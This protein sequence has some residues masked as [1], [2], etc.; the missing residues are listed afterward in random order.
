M[1]P[2]PAK[3]PY[4][5]ITPAGGGGT[6]YKPTAPAGGA[7]AKYVPITGAGAPSSVTNVAKTPAPSTSPGPKLTQ[8]DYEA[9][10]TSGAGPKAPSLLSQLW[11]HV[12]STAMMPM[13]FPHDVSMAIEHAG[14]FG[15]YDYPNPTAKQNVGTTQE[16]KQKYF[17][18]VTSQ[19]R[20]MGSTGQHLMNLAPIPRSVGELTG[21]N[22]GMHLPTG[23]KQNAQYYDEANKRGQIVSVLGQDLG[24]IAMFSG[25]GESLLGEA[26]HW[27]APLNASER[28]GVLG[29]DGAE[30]AGALQRANA[31]VD[32]LVGE[33]LQP[34]WVPGRGISGALQGPSPTASTFLPENAGLAQRR[35][36]PGTR[37]AWSA[38]TNQAVNPLHSIG[39]L[40]QEG[41]TKIGGPDVSAYRPS[42]FVP[43][44]AGAGL[45]WAAQ[46]SDT[47]NAVASH[48]SPEA[49]ANA[50]KLNDINAQ[51]EAQDLGA[52]RHALDPAKL[53]RHF[54]LSDDQSSAALNTID[55]RFFTLTDLIKRN[56]E[57]QKWVNGDPTTFDFDGLIN[58]IGS[59]VVAEGERPTPGMIREQMRFEAGLTDPETGSKMQSVIDSAQS[60]AGGR[61]QREFD[62]PSHIPGGQV[63]VG[64]VQPEYDEQGNVTNADEVGKPIMSTQYVRNPEHTGGGVSPEEFGNTLRPSEVAGTQFPLQA[65]A[66]KIGRDR[67]KIQ[68]RAMR[69]ASV[70]RSWDA[71]NSQ[72]PPPPNP[73]AERALG[74][75]TERDA[76]LRREHARSVEEVRRSVDAYVKI[77]DD[78]DPRAVAE[79]RARLDKANAR[80]DNIRSQVERT[81]RR[82]DA[83]TALSKASGDFAPGP[84]RVMDPTTGEVTNVSEELRQPEADVA[85][86]PSAKEI[87]D[88]SKQRKGDMQLQ[89][90]GE[91]ER[92]SN[93]T[94]YRWSGEGGEY[95]FASKVS[96]AERKRLTRDQ[97]FGNFNEITDS[98]GSSAPSPTSSAPTS[99]PVTLRPPATRR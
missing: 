92:I 58:G 94:K 99:W 73:T 8:A 15:Q 77:A 22:V 51:F 63:E 2:A 28:A 3:T 4:V 9:A 64:K 55:Q 1:A 90:Q 56:P 52:T 38:K 95:D 60:I 72:L 75:Y 19:V 88:R 66:S 70:A 11:G 39:D 98:N 80:E 45:S 43:K 82:Q 37:R 13:T 10:A 31:G 5:P 42:N 65:I 50:S 85:G 48:F 17:P 87:R 67:E 30:Q 44:A 89:T 18:E 78:G 62:A 79:A 54:K 97:H 76:V 26:G 33:Q 96:A 83:T 6:K 69:D 46:H 25:S 61:G 91:L 27:T 23:W 84:W 20:S 81:A 71:I 29:T 35:C 12:V 34:V 68:E 47:V 21:Q 40:A 93:G 49:R 7:T 41:L 24:N 59:G 53:A 32:P 14:K 16:I 36:Q 74:K 57:G 86:Q